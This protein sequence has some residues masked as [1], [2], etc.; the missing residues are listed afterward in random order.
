MNKFSLADPCGDRDAKCSAGDEIS[1]IYI[2]GVTTNDAKARLVSLATVELG[3]ARDV[4]ALGI[5]FYD[6][7]N[8][9]HRV[10]TKLIRRQQP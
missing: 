10:E 7:V 2:Y 1:G 8:N 3:K 4:R 5:W 9:K 6:N